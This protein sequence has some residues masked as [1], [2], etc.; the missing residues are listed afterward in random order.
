MI[1][2]ALWTVSLVVVTIAAF[3]VLLIVGAMIVEPVRK[4]LEKA[5]ER[6]FMELKK[7]LGY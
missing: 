1:H 2:L 4:S 7:H 5:R 3:I 6:R